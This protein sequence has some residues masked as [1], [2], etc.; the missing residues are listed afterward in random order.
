MDDQA[1]E[2]WRPPKRRRG[3]C[4]S[5][6]AA[7][8]VDYDVFLNHRGPDVKAGFV[9][10]LDEAL[11]AAGLNPFLDKASLRKGDPAFTSMPL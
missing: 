1:L 2:L 5:S 10:H 4:S 3:Q 11:R 8:D 7:T 6:F 9:A